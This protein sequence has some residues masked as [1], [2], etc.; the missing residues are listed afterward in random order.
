MDTLSRYYLIKANLKSS[1][2]FYS[3]IEASDIDALNNAFG[4][5]FI[6]PVGTFFF[7]YALKSI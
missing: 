5:M 6:C 2:A 1:D 7:I 3:H 4:Y